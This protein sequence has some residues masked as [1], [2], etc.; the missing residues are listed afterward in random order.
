MSLNLAQQSSLHTS[1]QVV[2]QMSL[3]AHTG[4]K[5]PK[6]S[7]AVVG[8]FQDFGEFILKAFEKDP[9]PALKIVRGLMV[10]RNQVLSKLGLPA[11][12]PAES[13]VEQAPAKKAA[14]KQ[15]EAQEGSGSAS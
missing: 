10:T 5:L 9:E 11:Y 2:E 4:K 12:A 13:P 8:K 3:C 1:R 15:K 6:E 14:S 7:Q